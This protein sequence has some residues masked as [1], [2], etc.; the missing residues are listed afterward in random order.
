MPDI[1]KC[2][3]QCGYRRMGEKRGVVGC[4]LH[5]SGKR[6]HVMRTDEWNETLAAPS[7]T[8]TVRRTVSVE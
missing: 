8:V 1:T 5:N 6:I 7:D 2:A 4:R 3:L